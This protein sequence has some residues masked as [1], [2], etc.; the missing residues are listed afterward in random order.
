[1]IFNNKYTMRIKYLWITAVA[2]IT[3]VICRGLWFTLE[4]R[5][6]TQ[7]AESLQSILME[8]IEYLPEEW[9]VVSEQ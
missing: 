9:L 1:M 2:V 4:P 3:T 8:H 6:T 5:T 7:P